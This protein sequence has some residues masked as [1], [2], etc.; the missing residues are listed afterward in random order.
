MEDKDQLI[1]HKLL[2]FPAPL[3]RVASRPQGEKK[4][5]VVSKG[6]NV[7][8]VGG[9]FYLSHKTQEEMIKHCRNELPYEACGL[10]SG[11]NGI[12]TTC[13]PMKN[14]HKSPVSFAMD[15]NQIA[16]VFDSMN[17]NGESLL[18]IYHSHPTDRAHPSRA[19]ITYNNYPELGYFVI[20]LTKKHPVVKCFCM[21]NNKV[22]ELKV[23]LM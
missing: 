12:A 8:L 6:S 1:H 10:L 16:Q 15:K 4:G 21:K 9:T 7:N 19:D 22:T 2:H 13:W 17:K 5:D 18:G 11:R 3:A 20:S 14:I 23:I